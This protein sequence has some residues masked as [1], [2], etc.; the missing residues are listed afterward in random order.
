MK[1]QEETADLAGIIERLIA[2]DERR[3]GETISDW[4]WR[5][6]ENRDQEQR[7]KKEN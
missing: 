7:L 6:L 1:T 2:E 5:W 3:A 4:L